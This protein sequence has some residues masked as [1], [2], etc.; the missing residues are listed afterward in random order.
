M[1]KRTFDIKRVTTLDHL[2]GRQSPASGRLTP[3]A[4]AWQGAFT[5]IELL[6]VIAIIAILA[7]ILLPVLDKA[8]QRGLAAQCISNEK[9]LALGWISYTSDNDDELMPNCGG[10]GKVNISAVGLNGWVLGVLTWPGSSEAS[11]YGDLDDTNVGYL[12]NSKMGPYI[13]DTRVYKCPS[14]IWKVTA[15][16]INNDS[17]SDRVRS[18]AMNCCMEGNAYSAAGIKTVP[19]DESWW[20]T[21][22]SGR[23]PYYAYNKGSDLHFGPGP[24]NLFVFCDDQADSINDGCFGDEGA[25][26]SAWD[27]L[28]ACYHNNMSSFSFADGHAELH[29]WLIGNEAVPV[30]EGNAT[31]VTIGTNP[32][33]FNWLMSHSTAPIPTAPTGT[34]PP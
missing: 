28:P 10:D 6:V 27:S 26:V 30:K 29:R 12:R 5:L 13:L 7:A 15:P 16:D 3:G 25:T 32:V 31:T 17:P 24:A 4:K 1:K 33:D 11:T 23:G 18:I 21:Q 19:A 22:T 34:G 20:I 9:Q 8:K 14:D 2:A